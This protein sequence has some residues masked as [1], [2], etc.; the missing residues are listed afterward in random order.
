MKAQVEEIAMGKGQAEGQAE[1]EAMEEH[2]V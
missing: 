1:D 2:S